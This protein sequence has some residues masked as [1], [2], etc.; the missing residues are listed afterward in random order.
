MTDRSKYKN[1]HKDEFHTVT[2]VNNT[3][4]PGIWLHHKY[5]GMNLSMGAKDELSAYREAFI[6]LSE[7]L[8]DREKQLCNL[9]KSIQNIQEIIAPYND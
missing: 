8:K 5:L 4:N 7:Y 2:H 9:Q 3:R 6:K 1:L